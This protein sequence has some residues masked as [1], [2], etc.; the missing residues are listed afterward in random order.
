M[1][2]L[3]LLE[4]D[5]KNA[6]PDMPQLV[7][8]LEGNHETPKGLNMSTDETFVNGVAVTQV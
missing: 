1:K 3:Q 6:A 5:H 8:K 4:G 7:Y 2:K